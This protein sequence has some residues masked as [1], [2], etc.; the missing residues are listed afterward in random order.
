VLARLEHEEAATLRARDDRAPAHERAELGDEWI[1]RLD[2]AGDH[3]R[4][5]PELEQA[6]R[7]RERRLCA[8]SAVDHREHG[9]L[10]AEIDGCVARRSGLHEVRKLGRRRC[11]KPVRDES[12]EKAQRALDR[13]VS[14]TEREPRLRRRERRRAERA[15]DRAHRERRHPVEAP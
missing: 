15:L 9:A 6:H 10:E 8:R 4:G 2:R 1:V 11:P 7:P 5:D 12:L 13:A 14:V 3:R